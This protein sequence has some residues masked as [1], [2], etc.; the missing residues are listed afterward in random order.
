MVGLLFATGVGAG[1]GLTV[2]LKRRLDKNFREAGVQDFEIPK[3][4][5]KA[6]DLVHVSTGFLL[7]ATA[8]MAVIVLLSALVL[9]K[10]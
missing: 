8:C 10:K 5:D 6:L 1:F 9:A 4:I 7:T 3:N 2:D